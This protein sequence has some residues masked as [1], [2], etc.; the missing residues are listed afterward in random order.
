M[1]TSADE[2]SLKILIVEDETVLAMSL[3]LLIEVRGVHT[4][5][6]IADDLESALAEIEIDW[7]DLALVDIQLARGASGLEVAAALQERGIPCLFMTGNPPTHPRPDLAVGVLCKPFADGAFVT[8]LKLMSAL[9]EGDV[10]SSVGLP[11]EIS[12]YKDQLCANNTVLIADPAT[13]TSGSTV[14]SISGQ[15]IMKGADAA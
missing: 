10:V 8:A 9:I 4:V 12:L 3:E 6:G 11:E 15:L 7:P 2:K 1:S 13:S 14:H 5:T